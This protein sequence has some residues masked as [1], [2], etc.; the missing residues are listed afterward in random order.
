MNPANN[1]LSTIERIV[2]DIEGEEEKDDDNDDSDEIVDNIDEDNEEEQ[3]KFHWEIEEL[4]VPQTRVLRDGSINL[5]EKPLPKFKGPT[6]GPVKDYIEGG[7]ENGK[8]CQTILD[9]F[10][11]YITNAMIQTF[12][13]ATNAYGRT[14]MSKYWKKDLTASEFKAFLAIV[15]YS[16]LVKF[17]DRDVMFSSGIYGSQ[18]VRNLMTE[19]RFSQILKA[20]HYID[21]TQFTVE[22]LNQNKSAD[23][24]WPVKSFVQALARTFERAFN[25]GQFMDIDEQCCPW[26]GRHK[27]RCYNP[28]KPE[29]WHF[30]LFALNDAETSY[31][32]RFY[33]YQGKSEQRPAGVSATLWPFHCLIGERF[34]DRNHIFV[35]D[36]WYTSMN[37]MQFVINTGNHAIGTVKT[38]KSG[39]PEVG[40]FPKTGNG[41]KNRGE[42]KQMKTNVNGKNVYFLAW[43]DNKPVH[44]LST[45]PSELGKVKRNSNDKGGNWRR[46]E[47]NRPSIIKHYNHG[48]GGTDGIDQRM[49]Y[50][51]PKVKTVSWIPKIFIHCLNS[52]V[53]NAFIV[54]R[55]YT[56]NPKKYFLK[57]FIMELIMQ[58]AEDEMNLKRL[59][60]APQSL[61]KRKSLQTWNKDRSRLQNY[62]FPQSIKL[63]EGGNRNKK[64]GDCMLCRTTTTTRC[65]QCDIHLCIVE[66]GRY[67]SCFQQFH[68]QQDISKGKVPV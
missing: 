38:N 9:F 37:S 45:I 15:I 47:I 31:Q 40:K 50:Y 43:Q 27:C 5:V 63:P 23:P 32:Y 64:Q 34:K 61:N 48:M 35:T 24:F 10:C 18:F 7:N 42:S 19:T 56:G 21:Y 26:K 44:L 22:Q 51:R 6:P 30:K 58:L 53:V 62:H 68:T 59:N 20:W 11:L 41:R 1:A 67:M 54:Y 14:F 13:S 60:E 25:P 33:L 57:D 66:D 39:L 49:S 3:R 28:S 17:P 29:K 12:V 36:N 8:H 2:A 46:V 55:A 65:K 52:A 4:T 16:G